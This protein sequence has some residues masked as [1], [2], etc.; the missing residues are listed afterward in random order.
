[1][2]NDRSQF[3]VL[4]V[5]LA[6]AV[7]AGCASTRVNQDPAFNGRWATPKGESFAI[8]P[9]D[10]LGNVI[11]AQRPDGSTVTCGQ[12]LTVDGRTIAQIRMLDVAPSETSNVDLYSFGV[13]ERSGDLLLHRAIRPEWFAAH[14]REH[15]ARFL[16]TDSAAP[17]SGVALAS[18]RADLE[19]LLRAALSDPTALAPAERFTRI[20]Q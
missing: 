14:A 10:T 2:L 12:L 6:L 9:D 16:R 15:N 5:S 18:N 11:R 1:M 7:L 8:V 17:G 19:S 3:R 4:I 13:L 20:S